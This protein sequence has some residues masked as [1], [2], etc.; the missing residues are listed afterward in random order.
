MPNEIE[1][2]LLIDPAH[3]I[4]FLRHPLLKMHTRQRPRT[5]RVLSIYYDT[6]DLTLH[7]HRIAVRLRHIGQRWLQTV[8]TEGRVSAGLHERPE[9]EYETAENTLNFER[10]E[11]P[12][13][14][15]FFADVTLRHTLR[16]VFTTEFA[17]T[18]RILEWPSGEVVELAL[19]RGE[20]RAG[21]R[22]Q[23]ICEVELELKAGASGRLFEFALQLQDTIPLRLE[24]VSKAE[25]GYQLAANTIVSPAKAQTPTLD[26]QLSTPEAFMDIAQSCIAH[27]QANE[28]GVLQSDDPE[29][30]HQMRV[31]VR[32]LRSA[33][34]VFSEIIDREHVEPIREELRWL[35]KELDGA[36]NW[37]VF[38]S[39][40]LPPIV[41]TFPEHAGFTWLVDQS[42][43][44]RTQ[45]NTQAR[46]AVAS[47]RYQRFLFAFG[48]WLATDVWQAQRTP[49]VVG[50]AEPPLTEFAARLLLNRHQ[51]LKRRGRHWATLTPEE[52]HAIRIAA[53]KLR[54]TAEFF[55]SLY[56]RKRTRRYIT[57]LAQLQ[58]LLGSMNDAATT[59]TLM[60]AIPM[61][62]TNAQQ[63]QAIGIVLGWVLGSSYAQL[64]A[65]E[66]AWHDFLDC[67]TFWS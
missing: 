35:T 8:K 4:R 31:A 12:K 59:V 21:D 46:A 41:S 50:A 30:V 11:D 48:S 37:D 42:A 56:P 32:R 52:R 33:L 62:D 44:F 10:L 57:A 27:V 60:Q 15:D 19:D 9:W 36:R 6:P 26:S 54:Y 45:T 49:L 66:A 24:N 34:S 43:V 53:K 65:L 40:T 51:R 14:R 67:Q 16:P 47:A 55:S 58:D 17:R 3:L 1:L 25:R 18:R 29:F 20:I 22:T 64:A 61:T 23:P 13:L 5:Q 2:K 63:Q 28:N 7:K 39:R 38:V